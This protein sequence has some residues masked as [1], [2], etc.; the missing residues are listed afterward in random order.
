MTK[1]KVKDIYYKE[2]TI[3]FEDSME[4]WLETVSEEEFDDGQSADS[5]VD[6]MIKIGLKLFECRMPKQ[7]K[8]NTVH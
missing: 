5:K 4:I 8:C 6:N 2:M 1:P 3:A 7:T